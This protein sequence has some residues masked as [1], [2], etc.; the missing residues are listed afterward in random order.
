[1]TIIIPLT[2]ARAKTKRNNL[3]RPN[4]VRIL[5]VTAG[6]T[7]KEAG[8]VVWVA[9]RTWQKWEGE[10]GNKEKHRYPAEAYIYTFCDKMGLVYPPKWDTKPKDEETKAEPKEEAKEEPEKS[11]EVA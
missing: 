6:L 10:E 3:L 1:M 11:S 7:Q 4:Y 5:R 9:E 8:E 2:K